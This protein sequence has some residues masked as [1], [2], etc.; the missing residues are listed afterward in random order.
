MNARGR[1]VSVVIPAFR[2]GARALAAARQTRSQHLPPDVALEIVVVDDGSDDDTAA[3][4][5]ALST[6]EARVLR[7]TSNQGRSAA[8]NAGADAATG[9]ILVF[10]DSDCLPVGD[11]FLATHLK[12]LASGAVASTGAVTGYGGGFWERYQREASQRRERQ[13]REGMQ[14]AGSSQN[15]AVRRE[16]FV[17][18]GGFDTGY[19]RYGFEDRDLLLRLATLGRIVWSSEA[20]V[21]HLDQFDLAQVS[22]KMAE[23]GALSSPRFAGAHP[24]AYRALGFARLDARQRRWLR[25][26]GR[27]LDA[28]LPPLTRGLDLLLQRGWIP[29]AVKAAAVRLVTGLSYLAGT[30]RPTP[31]LDREVSVR[32]P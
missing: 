28:A 27:V 8:R 9:D 21:R 23:A 1:S 10:M 13:H 18:V 20:A 5:G 31:S 14:Y 30:S 12:A 7:L 29:Y 15:L 4:L 6:S 25:A 2:D 3:R 17:A 16:A 11:A 24:T 19:R 22:R 26:P 32:K